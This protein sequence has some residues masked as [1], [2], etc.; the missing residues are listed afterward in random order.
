MPPFY[1]QVYISVKQAGC[2]NL[3]IALNDA[4]R[5][6]PTLASDNSVSSLLGPPQAVGGKMRM[7]LERSQSMSGTNQGETGTRRRDCIR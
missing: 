1:V 3:K 4:L 2:E 6:H 7:Q 5:P